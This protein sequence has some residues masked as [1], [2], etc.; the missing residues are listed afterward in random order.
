MGELV[1][2]VDIV[3]N[4]YRQT[5][6]SGRF[7]YIFWSMF[8]LIYLYTSLYERVH[9]LSLRKDRIY[10]RWNYPITLYV[11]GAA[12]IT[13]HHSTLWYET[14]MP[15][16]RNAVVLGLV[17]FTV[18]LIGL[19]LVCLGRASIN[20]YWGPNIYDYGDRNRLIEIGIYKRTRHAIYDGQF[21]MT[22]GTVV[23][24][25]NLWLVF[26]PVM[27]LAINIWRAKREDR[28][29]NER[30]HDDFV[31]YRDR[32]PFFLFFA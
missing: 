24:V 1:T 23:M 29:L 27:T 15:L 8:I 30:F 26:F 18:M 9:G 4:M 6:V 21:L 17:G 28:D 22:C 2:V 16:A 32:T 3:I 5:T 19:V 20:S 13:V 11:L 14:A 12:A 7:A 10:K 25:N 31:R